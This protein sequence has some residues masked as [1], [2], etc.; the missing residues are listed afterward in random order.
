MVY[1]EYC[2][3]WIYYISLSLCHIQPVAKLYQ[4][5]SKWRIRDDTG[6]SYDITV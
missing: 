2:I 5:C 1:T 6:R 4:P 3:F